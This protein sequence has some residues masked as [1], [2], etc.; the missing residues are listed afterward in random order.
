MYWAVFTIIWNIDLSHVSQKLSFN[1]CVLFSKTFLFNSLRPSKFSIAC[2]VA[3]RHHSV[4]RRR[5]YLSGRECEL[6]GYS[7]HDD[8]ASLMADG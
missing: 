3:Y 5:Y 7:H 4:T 2:H 6:S 8:D 1:R